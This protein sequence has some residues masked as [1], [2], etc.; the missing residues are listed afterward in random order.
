MVVLLLVLVVNKRKGSTLM[1][2]R[3][4]EAP[5]SKFSLEFSLE[6]AGTFP[7]ENFHTAIF[8]HFEKAYTTMSSKVAG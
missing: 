2:T 4:L 3:V 6:P 1:E 5:I 7:N 8:Y